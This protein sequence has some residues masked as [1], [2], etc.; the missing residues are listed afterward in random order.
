MP[1]RDDQLV[2]MCRRKLQELHVRAAAALRQ[3]ADEDVNWRPNGES[4][5]I[6]NLAIHLAG[7]LHQRLEAGI[8]GLA[9]RRDRDAEFNERGPHTRDEVL[10]ILGGSLAMAD[11][12]LQGL[13]PGDLDRPQWV[14]DRETT[15]LDIMLSVTH[16]VAEHIG[17]MLYITKLR[18]GSAY[19]VVS[20]PHKKA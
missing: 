18:L 8:L 20:I 7:N 14:R 12:V 1:D 2:A 5:S 13:G 16:H 11:L 9:D 3:L 17:Q 19:R 4:N 6:A 10:A 15:V